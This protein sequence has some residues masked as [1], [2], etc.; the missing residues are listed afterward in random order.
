MA[1]KITYQGTSLQKAQDGLQPYLPSPDLVMA[2][3]VALYLKRP[4]L[5][6]GEPGCGKT[7]LAE[8]L[9]HEL[10]GDKMGKHFFQ[11]YIKSTTKAEE[12]LCTINYLQ[13][14]YDVNSKDEK[15]RHDDPKYQQFGV[16]AKA[17]TQDANESKPNILLIDEIDKADIDFPNDLLLELDKK[18]FVIPE[19]GQTIKATTDVVV[20][21]TSNRE[22]A[23]PDAF[24]RRCIF[25]YIKFPDKE[26]L[27]SIVK[28]HFKTNATQDE[29]IEKTVKRFWEIRQNMNEDK[30][31][32]TSELLDWYNMLQYCQELQAE[33]QNRTLT[34]QEEELIAQAAALD[35][36]DKIPFKQ[37]L[38]KTYEAYHS[39]A[40]N[41]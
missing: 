28:A 12:G 19:T 38:L 16:L 14:L 10:H 6:M 21:I 15:F 2:V 32:A 35:S 41:E 7:R 30:K 3:N 9:A 5:L 4:L 25:F 36:S 23:L 22:R 37:V 26:E 31:I 33:K 1:H 29:L 13:R 18:E 40:D 39:D 20:I 24:L 34:T 17:F 11:W 8:A 27:Q